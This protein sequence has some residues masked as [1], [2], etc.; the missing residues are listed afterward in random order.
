MASICIIEDEPQIRELLGLILGE[1][2]N[3][4]PAASAKEA[5]EHLVHEPK[6]FLIDLHLPGMNGLELT[7]LIRTI[8]PTVPIVILTALSRDKYESKARELG[9][10]AFLEKPFNP[11][12]LRDLVSGLL[13][14]RKLAN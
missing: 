14:A 6:L 1:D 8:F 9:A 4:L 10:S 5:I 7:K 13:P 2:C 3:L 12:E 11:G